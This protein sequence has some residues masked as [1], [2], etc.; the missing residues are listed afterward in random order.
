MY[1]LYVTAST[2]DWS[3][4]EEPLAAAWADSVPPRVRDELLPAKLRKRQE[5]IHGMLFK[6][7]EEALGL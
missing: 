5:V 6:M 1:T 7:N 4:E 2:S 3:D